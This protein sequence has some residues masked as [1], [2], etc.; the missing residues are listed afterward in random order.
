MEGTQV[1]VLGRAPEEILADPARIEALLTS[2]VERLAMRLLG[3]PL[4]YEVPLEI[5]KLGAEPFEDE[6]GVTGIAVLSTSHISIHTWP[7]RGDF[8]MDV[9]S[10]R[11]FE[12]DEVRR[13]LFCKLAAYAVQLTDLSYALRRQ[14]SVVETRAPIRP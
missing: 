3:D 9:Y 13:A 5:E 14:P 7:L 2:L 8:V 6:G 12:P 10:C 4:L 1:K 11:S